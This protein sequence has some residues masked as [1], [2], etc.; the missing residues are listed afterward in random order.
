MIES[1]RQ[2]V[3]MVEQFVTGQMTRRQFILR[4]S[5]LGL[6][7]TAIGTILA[8]CGTSASPSA[9]GSAPSG[10][11]PSA[12]GGSNGSSLSGT[13]KYYKGPFASNEAD[14]EATMVASFNQKFPNVEVV[15]EQFDWPSSA[16]QITA[17]LGSGAHDV[18]YMPEDLYY[19]FAATG[20]LQDLTNYV[21]DPAWKDEH[22]LINFWDV[23][24][25]AG[26]P[27]V[28]V[29]YIWLVESHLFYNKDLFAK[30]GIGD[31]WNSTYDKLRETAMALTS[32][33]V[34]G[35]GLRS[36]GGANYGKHDWYGMIQRAGT[37]FLDSSM[38]KAAIN[39]PE[40]A[41]SIQFFADMFIKDK[42]VPEFGKYTWDQ[43][44]GL[45]IAGKS[46]IACDETTF[47]TT[48]NGANPKPTFDWAMAAWPKGPGNQAQFTY[49]GVLTMSSKSQN[50]DAAWEMM[51]HW[52]SGPVAVPYCDTVSIPS[53]RS[54]AV[55]KYNEFQSNPQVAATLDPF[56]KL[57]KGPQAT[58]KFQQF[59]TLTDP[60][61][62][63][64]YQ[65]SLSASDALAQA[66]TAINDA[67]GS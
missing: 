34:V 4:L 64:C 12:G 14:L 19:Q 39:T 3:N 61:I 47:A 54:D 45:F 15:V 23:A 20:Q 67:M 43:L 53:V 7:A 8:A 2:T 33:D 24:T 17:S 27:P 1:E 25:A 49:R 36:S 66:E 60:L 16:Q 44:R 50:Q 55:S 6:S 30:A 5:A 40:A 37:D 56:S 42:C 58:P 13:V 38:T 62:D 52:S 59:M 48:I 28:G 26:T 18:Y 11:A 29:P 10:A 22:D 35:M 41:Q 21:N 46:A 9:T 51:K 65:G 57:A 32:G 63:A 31:D